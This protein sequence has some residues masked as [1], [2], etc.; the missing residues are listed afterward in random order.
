MVERQYRAP[1]LTQ[2]KSVTVALSPRVVGV[3]GTLINVNCSP[4]GS[5]H[6]VR[7]SMQPVSLNYVPVVYLPK[8]QEVCGW[9]L[10]R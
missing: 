6:V 3:G 2:T 5:S 9:G 4:L 7:L 8:A 1:V 10:Q